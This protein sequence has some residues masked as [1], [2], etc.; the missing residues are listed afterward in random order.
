MGPKNLHLRRY[1]FKIVIFRFVSKNQAIWTKICQNRMKNNRVMPTR[2]SRSKVAVGLFWAK[3]DI[4]ATFFKISTFNLFCQ[5]FA[6]RLIG[7][8]N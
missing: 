3:I 4:L 8:P 6:L 5:V 2:M 1:S 7:K